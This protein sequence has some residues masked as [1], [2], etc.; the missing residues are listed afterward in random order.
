MNE[1]GEKC[2]QNIYWKTLRE[3]TTWKAPDME[4]GS[5]YQIDLKEL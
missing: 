2:V 5:N 1:R 3:E 4:G